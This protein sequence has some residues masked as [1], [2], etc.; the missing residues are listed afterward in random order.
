MVFLRNWMILLSAK[1]KNCCWKWGKY[2]LSLLFNS[3]K[4][5]IYNYS[6]C[7][8]VISGFASAIGG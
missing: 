8:K 2:S 6:N 5:S 7:C 4:V 1:F 3:E